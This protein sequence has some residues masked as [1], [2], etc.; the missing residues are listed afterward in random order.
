MKFLNFTGDRIN[1]PLVTTNSLVSTVFRNV[2]GAS[3]VNSVKS[4]SPLAVS[5]LDP[6]TVS[7]TQITAHKASMFKSNGQVVMMFQSYKCHLSCPTKD[8][9]VYDL[10]ARGYQFVLLE[11]GD[12]ALIQSTGTETPPVP[13][14]CTLAEYNAVSSTPYTGTTASATTSRTTT[15]VPADVDVDQVLNGIS[16]VTD[17]STKS[18]ASMSDD[19]LLELLP[20][21][22]QV[23]EKKSWDDTTLFDSN[24]EFDEEDKIIVIGDYLIPYSLKE[25]LIASIF[26][27]CGTPPLDAFSAYKDLEFTQLAKEN[28]Y[29]EV[30]TQLSDSA[31]SISVDKLM[32]EAIKPQLAEGKKLDDLMCSLTGFVLHKNFG[33]SIIT[34]GIPLN[35]LLFREPSFRRVTNS[36]A[37]TWSAKLANKGILVANR[38]LIDYDDKTNEDMYFIVESPRWTL[39]SKCTINKSDAYKIDIH[40]SPTTRIIKGPYNPYEKESIDNTVLKFSIKYKDPAIAP[41]KVV[42]TDAGARLQS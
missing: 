26:C 8:S 3:V 19:E 5:N 30:L 16:F 6:F 9:T 10:Q 33:K 7:S 14:F 15:T 29:E 21:G 2:A 42:M 23:R 41:I 27:D 40:M 17:R 25:G 1:L 35:L 11:A 22:S 31:D 18:V 12:A 32:Y 39:S 34:F 20:G 28:A 24:S 36:S 4:F 37:E 38:N 13:L